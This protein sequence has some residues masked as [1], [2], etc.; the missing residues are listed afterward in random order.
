[1]HEDALNTARDALANAI[2]A[3]RNTAPDHDASALSALQT[4]VASLGDARPVEPTQQPPAVRYLHRAITA[5]PPQTQSLAST[6][7][8]IAD[9]VQWNL[10]YTDLIGHDPDITAMADGYAFAL[11]A[12]PTNDLFSAAPYE[13]DGMILGWVIQGPN[14]NYPPHH[15]APVEIYGVISGE[16]TWLRDSTETTRQPGE[17]FVH[18]AWMAHATTTAAQ[19]TLSW[20]AWTDGSDEHPLLLSQS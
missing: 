15:H 2:A 17:V 7:A 9:L 5:A 14:I 16:A 20:V 13:T 11:L 6:L 4:L 18:D 3:A 8:D 10:A 1:M 19:P 12:G